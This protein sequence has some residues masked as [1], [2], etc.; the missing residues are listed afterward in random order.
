MSSL[1]YDDYDDDVDVYDD[2]NGDDDDDERENCDDDDEIGDG[3]DYDCY[4][5]CITCANITCR[6]HVALLRLL[7]LLSIIFRHLHL[8]VSI[9]PFM[10]HILHHIILR[11]FLLLYSMR[12]LCSMMMIMIVLMMMLV[13]MMMVIMVVMVIMVMHAMTM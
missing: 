10:V 2:G 13:M 5:Y 7:L 12:P 4:S 1:L 6:F 11:I 9:L 8:I 3:G